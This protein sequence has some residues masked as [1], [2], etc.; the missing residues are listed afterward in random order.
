MLNVL[1]FL[2]CVIASRAVDGVLLGILNSIM[3][4]LSE[5]A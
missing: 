4:N 1:C 2:T 3:P 5:A